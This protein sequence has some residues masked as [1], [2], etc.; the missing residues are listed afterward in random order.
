MVFSSPYG[1]WIDLNDGG[2]SLNGADLALNADQQ[3]FALDGR[4]MLP[5]RAVAEALGCTVVWD[6]AN[7]GQIAVER[8]G[9]RLFAFSLDG[10]TVTV[11]GDMVMSL[12]H[13]PVSV[14]GVTFLAAEDVIRVHNLKLSQI[15]P[16]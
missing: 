3:P 12:A 9:E 8:S 5:V 14:N 7:P 1:G 6:P 4:L 15:S 2:I 11:E 16:F 10:D 13:K